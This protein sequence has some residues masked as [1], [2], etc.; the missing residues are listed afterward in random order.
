MIYGDVDVAADIWTKI[1]HLTRVV[2]KRQV[3]LKSYINGSTHPP[4]VGDLLIYARAFYGTG[5]VAVVTKVNLKKGVIKVG[6]QKYNN[7]PW[8][9]NY[10]RRIALYKKDD[11]YWLLDGYILG[12]KHPAG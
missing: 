4:R 7:M 9:G 2:D 10:A 8:P 1:D 3:P 5:H 11:H 12:W 6:E